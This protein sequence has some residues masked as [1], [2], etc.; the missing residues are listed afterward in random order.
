[1]DDMSSFFDFREAAASV[2]S[3]TT[4]SDPV[5]SIGRNKV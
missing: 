5:Q 3:L 4:E 1:M 2:K